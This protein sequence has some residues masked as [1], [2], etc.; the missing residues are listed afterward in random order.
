MPIKKPTKKTKLVT[1]SK[2][3]KKTRLKKPSVLKKSR[4]KISQP[5]KVTFRS[6]RKPKVGR[7]K[8]KTK[9]KRLNKRRVPIK[10]TP[11]TI[12]SRAEPYME[13]AGVSKRRPEIIFQMNYIP[14]YRSDGKT[15]NTNIHNIIEAQKSQRALFHENN[16][17]ILDRLKEIP[18]IEDE[19]NEILEGYDETI[20]GLH[21]VIG[22]LGKVADRVNDSKRKLDF[23]IAVEDIVESFNDREEKRVKNRKAALKKTI[24]RAKAKAEAATVMGGDATKQEKI[25]NRTNRAITRLK[26]RTI[27][28]ASE[29][30]TDTGFTKAN[31]LNFSNTK[32]LAQTMFDLKST[33]LNQSPLLLGN[34]ERARRIDSH[35]FD[36]DDV[37]MGGAPSG[38][39]TFSLSEVE[40]DT[41]YNSYIMGGRDLPNDAEDRFRILTNEIS[42]EARYSINIANTAKVETIVE[43]TGIT[44]RGNQS[45]QDMFGNPETAF[46]DGASLSG[47]SSTLQMDFDGEKVFPYENGYIRTRDG[48]T[49]MT[50]GTIGVCDHILESGAL[51]TSRYATVARELMRSVSETYTVASNMYFLGGTGGSI[52]RPRLESNAKIGKVTFDFY[53]D[54]LARALYANIY[55]VFGGGLAYMPG[56]GQSSGMTDAEGIIALFADLAE[57][58]K[59]AKYIIILMCL[60]ARRKMKLEQDEALKELISEDEDLAKML[61]R[62]NLLN[63]LANPQISPKIMLRLDEGSS[64][65]KDDI[66]SQDIDAFTSSNEANKFIRK[67]QDHLAS[68]SIP[69]AYGRSRKRSFAT[70]SRRYRS[71]NAVPKRRRSGRA[72]PIRP[73]SA[74]TGVEYSNYQTKTMLSLMG[75]TN[76]GV[77]QLVLSRISE[78][79]DDFIKSAKFRV[80]PKEM[81]H[82]Q[83]VGSELDDEKAEATSALRSAHRAMRTANRLAEMHY[84][85]ADKFDKS[86]D[87][88]NRAA[89]H[90]YHRAITHLQSSTSPVHQGAAVTLQRASR[91]TG[92][93]AMFGILADQQSSKAAAQRQ[94]GD[95]LRSNAA[96]NVSSAQ[97]RA[98]LVQMASMA[99]KRKA[100]DVVPDIFEIS[101]PESGKRSSRFNGISEDIYEL[102]FIDA[103]LTFLSEC[104]DLDVQKFVDK[105]NSRRT[106]LPGYLKSTLTFRI[107]NTQKRAFSNALKEYTGLGKVEKGYAD[108]I[109]DIEAEYYENAWNLMNG[110]EDALERERFFISKRLRVLRMY[111]TNLVYEGIRLNRYFDVSTNNTSVKRVLNAVLKTPGSAT[112]ISALNDHQLRL[113]HYMAECLASNAEEKK[114]LPVPDYDKFKVQQ[115]FFLDKMMRERKFRSNRGNNLNILAVGLPCGMIKDLSTSV[116]DNSHRPGPY[117]PYKKNTMIKINVFKRDQQFDDLVFKP[118][119]Y[120]YDDS[121]FLSPVDSFD[122]IKIKD[123]FSDMMVERLAYM[124]YGIEGRIYKEGQ[125]YREMVADDDF[126]LIRGSKRKSVVTNMLYSEGLKYYIKLLT[127]INLN[128]QEFFLHPDYALSRKSIGKSAKQKRILDQVISLYLDQ[129]GVE[130]E[131]QY[132]Q[133]LALIDQLTSFTN[134]TIFKAR[135]YV[136]TCIQPTLFDRVYCVPVDPDDFE[137]D[138]RKTMSTKSGRLALRSALRSKQIRRRRGKYVLRPRR[139]SE[140]RV[141]IYEYFVTVEVVSSRSSNEKKRQTRD[142]NLA[143]QPRKNSWQRFMEGGD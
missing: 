99:L 116:F 11:L 77:T 96:A 138:V 40:E 76:D 67:L 15:K 46:Q 54:S 84:K 47:L 89:N 113:M 52:H 48:K 62:E 136:R 17:V 134:T 130:T 4:L 80:S 13:R 111:A 59:E 117:D 53:G 63:K 33:M 61:E 100:M 6:R 119:S 60:M 38:A 34:N 21:H 78:S 82:A 16:K 90:P 64:K 44:P 87:Q 81:R 1:Q 20:Q 97:D 101:D 120:F 23:K 24:E 14:G 39:G 18:E 102:L 71:Q 86:A 26:A 49:I 95:T 110:S 125:D 91:A 137:I 43:A 45:I 126:R 98:R 83:S 57:K 28:E 93:G 75:D 9:R 114:E 74:K 36:I 139:K 106:A 30:M 12:S 128:E 118:I 37:I 65:N 85:T 50:P 88:L 27:D 124:D 66:F 135:E 29:I 56:S 104:V 122:K 58:D 107:N 115:L 10:K 132:A 112:I 7:L 73:N 131:E 51:D 141:A 41:L 55:R 22:E 68:K 129:E 5:S 69:R 19:I 79:Y 25:I 94:I 103:Q 35:P 92:L 123:K 2:F 8:F 143:E 70:A 105:R 31:Y 127:G 109:V 32:I 42:K 3:K 133:H 121:R 140:G 108:S 72:G 142:L